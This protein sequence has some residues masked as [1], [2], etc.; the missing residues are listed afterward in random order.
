MEVKAHAKFL[1]LSPRKA[2]LIVNLVKGKKALDAISLLSLTPQKSSREV[3]KI[4]NSALA[5]A[6]SN[7]GLSKNNLFIKEIKADTGPTFK[8]YKPR[9]RGSA[10]VIKRKMTHLTVI[11]EQVEGKS[12]PS[13]VKEVASK[14]KE[15]VV[16]PLA[17][18]EAKVEEKAK[19]GMEK[20]AIK[21]KEVEE[22]E[23][24]KPERAEKKAE[25]TEEAPKVIKKAKSEKGALVKKE[26]AKTVI[27]KERETERQ[28]KEK[29]NQKKE[30][31]F[32]GI[33]RFFRRK[34]F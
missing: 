3:I 1:R 34:G 14:I 31:F 16:R 11:L 29:F 5:N 9:A 32:G 33:K 19:E 30:S 13:K 27:K 15:K 17:K 25:K 7:L 28:Q 23:V 22:A 21:I 18:K 24:K 12:K 4:L 2:R 8:R 6:R 10:D 20:E 26:K